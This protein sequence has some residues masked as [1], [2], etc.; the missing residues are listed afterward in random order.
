MS[1][2]DADPAATEP[3]ESYRAAAEEIESILGQIERDRNL[4]VDRLADH[5]ER[6]SGLIKFCYDR[7]E[8]AEMRVRKVTDDLASTTAEGSSP[9]GE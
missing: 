7:L 6:A 4:D 3:P 5:V 1:P 9:D 8:K 2:T